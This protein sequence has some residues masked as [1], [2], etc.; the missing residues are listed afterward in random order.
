VPDW[1]LTQHAIE[2]Y[3]HV[4]GWRTADDARARIELQELA[5]HATYRDGVDGLERWRSPKRSGGGLRWLID[6]RVARGDL[7]RVVWV[8][9]GAPPLDHFLGQRP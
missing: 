3:Q 5:Q 7:P 2:R 6:T 4:R 9:Y 1:H 8:G